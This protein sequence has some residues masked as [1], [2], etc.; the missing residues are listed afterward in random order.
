[1]AWIVI[2]GLAATVGTGA[3]FVSTS[4]S[5]LST[6]LGARLV[7]WGVLPKWFS[8]RR[9]KTALALFSISATQDENPRLEVE[10]CLTDDEAS[11]VADSL[12]CRQPQALAI[13]RCTRLRAKALET[14]L[15]AALS[16]KEHWSAQ[17]VAWHMSAF[18]GLQEVDLMGCTCLGDE[19]AKMLG[20]FFL[21]AATSL[22]KLGLVDCGLTH[23]GVSAM[24]PQAQIDDIPALSAVNIPSMFCSPCSPANQTEPAATSQKTW[25]APPVEAAPPPTPSLP[26]P[27]PPDLLLRKLL[28]SSNALSGAGAALATLVRSFPQLEQLSLEAC[29][30]GVL[31]IQQLAKALPRSRLAQLDLAKNALRSKGLLALTG[32]LRLSN[33]QDLGLERN[34]IGKGDALFELKAA[35]DRRPFPKLRLTGNRLTA[36]QEDAFLKT[37]AKPSSKRLHGRST[38]PASCKCFERKGQ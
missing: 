36:S 10:S 7:L 23:E 2:G 28:L 16:H 3:V 26:M 6:L 9:L 12:Q 15:V 14:I 4:S 37:L 38:C 20:C 25:S 34:E 8:R 30:L 5:S 17:A 35:H 32:S 11:V 18:Q 1:M 24:A 13:L 31:D 27:P 29:S 21:R 22:E 19:L 33:I